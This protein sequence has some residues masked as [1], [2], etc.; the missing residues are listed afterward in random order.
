M[1]AGLTAGLANPQS[2]L[3]VDQLAANEPG[4]VFVRTHTSLLLDQLAAGR[5]GWVADAR[6]Q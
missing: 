1:A 5:R 4:G 6:A 2:R 3:S